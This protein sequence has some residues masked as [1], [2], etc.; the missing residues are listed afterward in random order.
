VKFIKLLT[1][2]QQELFLNI[3]NIVSFKQDDDKDK[4]TIILTINNN[5][6]CVIHTPQQIMDKI[7]NATNSSDDVDFFGP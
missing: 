7:D 2:N 4:T 1:W 5:R 3:N 6:Y